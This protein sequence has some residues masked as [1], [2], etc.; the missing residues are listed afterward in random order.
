MQR[1]QNRSSVSSTTQRKGSTAD[2]AVQRI[3]ILFIKATKLKIQQGGLRVTQ[4]HKRTLE[5]DN[6]HGRCMR[7]HGSSKDKIF[8]GGT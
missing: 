7:L 5:I 4:V 6:P 1:G 8:A 3:L 2:V